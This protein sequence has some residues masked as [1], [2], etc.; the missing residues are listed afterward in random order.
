[1]TKNE[2]LH[3]LADDAHAACVTPSGTF[4]TRDVAHHFTAAVKE[5]E[6]SGDPWVPA[7]IDSLTVDGASKWLG[8]W[9]RKHRLKARTKKG[10]AVEPS[11]YAGR[12]ND[13]GGYEQM[14]LLDMDLVSLKAHADKLKSQR[15]TLSVE[16]RLL[17]DLIE[18]ME[19]DD[20]LSTVGAAFRKLGLAA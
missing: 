18:A 7:F 16:I 4:P 10:T 13:D 19:S 20:A 8:D 9:R 1:M 17:D 15:D 5:L 2:L 6:G 12:R 11:A 3:Q 14:R